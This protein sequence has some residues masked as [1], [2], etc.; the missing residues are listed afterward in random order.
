M[1]YSL[2]SRYLSSGVS[3]KTFL[4]IGCGTG[5]V[6]RMISQIPGIKA[7]GSEIHLSGV[8]IASQRVPHVEVFQM[9]ALR[10]EFNQCYDAIGLFDVLEHLDDDIEVIR[11]I[12]KAL[13]PGGILFVTVPQYPSL[14]SPQD[15]S[16][17]HKRRYTQNALEKTVRQNGFQ[18]L[19]CGSFFCF[20]FPLYMVSRLHK[21]IFHSDKSQM[22]SMSEF[23]IPSWLNTMFTMICA[24]DLAAIRLGIRL[25]FGS[26]LALVA[27]VA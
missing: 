13:V 17:G 20:I 19:Y 5:F 26:S 4:E 16:A 25:P 3:T 2:I 18:T 9:D 14:W 10:M 6:L 11:R 27:Q 22:R 15:T 7:S 21:R 24:L 12:R 1:L 23:G 8:K